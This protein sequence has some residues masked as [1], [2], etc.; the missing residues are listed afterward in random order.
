MTL[1]TVDGAPELSCAES[2]ER[3]TNL[4]TP[5]AVSPPTATAAVSVSGKNP[6]QGSRTLAALQPCDSHG[7]RVNKD[8]DNMWKLDDLKTQIFNDSSSPYDD[9]CVDC[10][11]NLIDDI[12]DQTTNDIKDTC[13]SGKNILVDYQSLN[14]LFLNSLCC[15]KCAKTRRIAARVE[16]TEKTIGLATTITLTCS[17]CCSRYVVEPNMTRAATEQKEKGGKNGQDRLGLYTVNWLFILML[18]KIGKGFSHG[19]TILAFLGLKSSTNI[20]SS[21]RSWKALEDEVGHIENNVANKIINN[22]LTESIQAHIDQF[23]APSEANDDHGENACLDSEHLQVKNLVPIYVSIDGAWQQRGFNSKSG[24]TF[25]VCA[26]TK[27]IIEWSTKIKQCRFCHWYERGKKSLPDDHKVSC[28]VNHDGSSKSMEAAAAVEVTEKLFER[29]PQCVQALKETG[30]HINASGAYIHT[31][32]HDDDSTIAANTKHKTEGK[33]RGKGKLPMHVPEVVQHLADPNHRC[34]TFASMFFSWANAAKKNSEWKFTKPE[35]EQLKRYFGWF[36][37]KCRNLPLEVMESKAKAIHNH[38]FDQHEYCSKDFCSFCPDALQGL[39]AEKLLEQEQKRKQKHYRSQEQDKKLY[40]AM[41]EY[42]TNFC[43]RVRLSQSNHPF[44]SQKNESLNRKAT[45]MLPKDVV[46]SGTRS[47]EYRIAVVIGLA[48]VG[49]ERYYTL[50]ADEFGI[51]LPLPMKMTLEKMDKVSQY[52]KEWR[53]MPKNKAK[54]TH[55]RKE[56]LRRQREEHAKAELDGATY[57][58]C[59]AIDST[60]FVEVA[61]QEVQDKPAK[62]QRRNCRKEKC[63]LC[64]GD[65][66]V[67]ARSGLCAFHAVLGKENT[68]HVHDAE[69][70]KKDR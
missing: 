51:D 6:K 54:R 48:S 1:E 63:P 44:D 55:D 24:H 17:K 46:Y 4:C 68:T 28:H 49:F 32:I 20:I 26:L 25:A 36:L 21:L 11:E 39:S 52:K 10:E 59:I 56:S 34:K 8:G 7:G 5:S 57:Q 18:Q 27:K 45:A 29:A 50:L 31:M 61:D 9:T 40:D 58:S 38:F 30:V 35:A 53:E 69:N 22:N 12:D 60:S 62:R 13:G 15:F 41:E 16:M 66:H 67:T 47:F 65:G 14:S 19:A 37:K 64:G 23:G 70:R 42:C 43:N 2:A 3:S 33:K